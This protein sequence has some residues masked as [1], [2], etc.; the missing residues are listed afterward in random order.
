MPSRNGAGAG[1]T[2]GW[3]WWA[4]RH[5]DGLTPL[6]LSEDP[7]VGIPQA[8]TSESRAVPLGPE[9][10]DIRLHGLVSLQLFQRELI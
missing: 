3:G 6:A 8:A 1:R 7:P 5:P 4:P 9:G 10:S 2:L